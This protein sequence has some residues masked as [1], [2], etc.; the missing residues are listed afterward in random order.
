[1]RKGFVGF[2]G[3]RGGCELVIWQ[4]YGRIQQLQTDIASFFLFIAKVKA[5]KSE[6]QICFNMCINGGGEISHVFLMEGGFG[7]HWNWDFSVMCLIQSKHCIMYHVLSYF[8]WMQMIWLLVFY[9][10]I[11]SKLMYIALVMASST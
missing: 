2:F 9:L 1:L 10:S 5:D 7:Y 8:Y 6:A 11:L 4:S 3:G